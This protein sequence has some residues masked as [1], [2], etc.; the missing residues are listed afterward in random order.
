M[1]KKFM[2]GD[3]IVFRWNGWNVIGFVLWEVQQFK[4]SGIRKSSVY[5]VEMNTK[6]NSMR[7]DD[8]NIM[9]SGRINMI[10]EDI[11]TCRMVLIEK[12]IDVLFS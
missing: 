5:I 8:G 12:K 11:F 2:L 1:D 10:A 4:S 9:P 6:R 7:D 3:T